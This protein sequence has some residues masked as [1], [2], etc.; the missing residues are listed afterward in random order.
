MSE[1]K[2]QFETRT[3]T[4][5]QDMEETT[6]KL[7]VAI[8][9]G[10]INFT[11]LIQRWKNM[12]QLDATYERSL[13]ANEGLTFEEIHFDYESQTSTS[14]SWPPNGMSSSNFNITGTVKYIDLFLRDSLFF[15][16]A[17]DFNGLDVVTFEVL[18]G[19]EFTKGQRVCKLE[20]YVQVFPKFDDTPQININ[21]SK[22]VNSSDPMDAILHPGRDTRFYSRSVDKGGRQEK[23]VYLSL[24]EDVVFGQL[25][26]IEVYD[27]DCIQVIDGSCYLELT[28]DGGA[29]LDVSLAGQIGRRVSVQAQHPSLNVALNQLKV[30]PLD[31]FSG[32]TNLTVT[33]QRVIEEAGDARGLMSTM[34]VSRKVSVFVRP[35]DDMPKLLFGF[36]GYRKLFHGSMLDLNAPFNETSYKLGREWLFTGGKDMDNIFGSQFNRIYKDQ[37]YMLA[38]VLNGKDTEDAEKRERELM[39]PKSVRSSMKYVNNEWEETNE[40]PVNNLVPTVWNTSRSWLE[41]RFFSELTHVENNKTYYVEGKVGYTCDVSESLS[42]IDTVEEC[43][44]AANMYGG[45]QQ[46]SDSLDVNGTGNVSALTQVFFRHLSAPETQC[47][48]RCSMQREPHCPNGI[49]TCFYWDTRDSGVTS[50]CIDKRPLCKTYNF[51]SEDLAAAQLQTE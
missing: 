25:P 38:D 39:C 23:V 4:V 12:G 47:A 36:P 41:E 14:Y 51:T 6:I 49:G 21:V 46:T 33:L 13:S 48:S 24:D 2:M 1:K 22:M 26:G 29:L 8:Q 9:F 45:W 43:M 37:A 5:Q 50:N 11:P 7:N 15:E 42:S 44:D 18:D 31:Q 17:K 10:L 28:I 30:T 34:T 3:I 40:H 35:K 27:P 32:F 16:P 20:T 19:L